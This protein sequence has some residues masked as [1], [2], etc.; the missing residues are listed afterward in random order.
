[1]I[2]ATGPS[3]AKFGSPKGVRLDQRPVLRA[4]NSSVRSRSLQFASQA[5]TGEQCPM[6]EV[7]VAK[8]KRLTSAGAQ[9][10][11]E[12]DSGKG[13]E[14]SSLTSHP[15]QRTRYL[16]TRDSPN[17][18]RDQRRDV[19]H[20]NCEVRAVATVVSSIRRMLCSG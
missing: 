7:C 16:T 8:R 4:G 13:G 15:C 9:E 20:A 10:L 19:G 12:G 2:A 1:M 18:Q 3:V 11:A 6:F 5:R 17:V 14:R